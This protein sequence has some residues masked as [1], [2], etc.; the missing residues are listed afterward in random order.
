MDA[1][2]DKDGMDICPAILEK[3]QLKSQKIKIGQE[4]HKVSTF[5]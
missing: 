1:V 2:Q 3:R 5:D 4:I